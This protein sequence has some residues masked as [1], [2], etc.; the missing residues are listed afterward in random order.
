MTAQVYNC[1]TG[2]A[3]P[4]AGPPNTIGGTMYRECWCLRLSDGDTVGGYRSRE[5]AEAA[6]K[7]RG[8]T[9]VEEAPPLW[10]ESHEI[11]THAV[12]AERRGR[13]EWARERQRREAREAREALRAAAALRMGEV[14]R[15]Q[16]DRAN[17]ARRAKRA[18]MN[19]AKQSEKAGGIE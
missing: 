4:N 2:N 19:A 6:A 13:R 7:A 5:G 3:D 15:A 18:A 1:S 14:K 16:R 17:A 9:I 11:Y 10:L 12:V 8:V